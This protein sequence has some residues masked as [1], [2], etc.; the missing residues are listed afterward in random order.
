MNKSI[1]IA[2]IILGS[3]AV[4]F[5]MYGSPDRENIS[6]ANDPSLVDH[7]TSMNARLAAPDNANSANRNP[8]GKG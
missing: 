6:V 7:A 4:S 1:I 5:V 8:F 2:A 3:A